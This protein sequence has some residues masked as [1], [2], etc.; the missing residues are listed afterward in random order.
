[1]EEKSNSEIRVKTPIRFKHS[2]E[3]QVYGRNSDLSIS[4]IDN[5]YPSD[6]FGNGLIQIRSKGIPVEN[7]SDSPKQSNISINKIQLNDDDEEKGK[8]YYNSSSN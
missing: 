5:E 2:N 4:V 7:M 3:D 1:M 8:Q 6:Y